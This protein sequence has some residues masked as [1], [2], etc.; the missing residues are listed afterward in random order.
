VLPSHAWQDV[1]KRLEQGHYLEGRLFTLGSL[2]KL[3]SDLQLMVA[4]CMQW[5]DDPK[6]PLYRDHA[7]VL[8]QKFTEKLAG[9]RNRVMRITSS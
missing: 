6:E 5:N 7:K 3:E 4:N 1:R 9:T 8:E 2:D